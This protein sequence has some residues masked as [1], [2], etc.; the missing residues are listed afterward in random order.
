[1][2]TIPQLVL[3]IQSG[4]E[5]PELGEGVSSLVSI[6]MLLPSRLLLS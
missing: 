2:Q 6:A 4:G 5:P 1:V 3:R